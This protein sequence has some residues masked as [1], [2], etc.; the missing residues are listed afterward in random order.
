MSTDKNFIYK[1]FCCLIIKEVSMIIECYF[2]ILNSF[3]L[4]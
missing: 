4:L 3:C 2:F 1:N